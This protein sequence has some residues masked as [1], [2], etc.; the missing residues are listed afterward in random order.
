[1][2][3]VVL[4]GGV[5]MHRELFKTRAECIKATRAW[6]VDAGADE[7]DIDTALLEHAN[8]MHRGWWGGNKVGFVDESYPGAVQ[9]TVV[10]LPERLLS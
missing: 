1:M 7:W 2:D 6:L 3:P 8:L 5:L 9:V 4:P 10:N